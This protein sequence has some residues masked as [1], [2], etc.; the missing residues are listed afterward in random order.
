MWPKATQQASPETPPGGGEKISIKQFGG[1]VRA[2]LFS[3][4]AGEV[5]VA[6]VDL[7]KPGSVKS[8]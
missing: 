6:D 8:G 2:V 7:D 4:K 3:G 1:K 5:E